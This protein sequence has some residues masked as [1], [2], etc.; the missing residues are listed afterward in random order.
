MVRIKNGNSPCSEQPL[1]SRSG[2]ANLLR[3]WTEMSSDPEH[4]DLRGKLSLI[5]YAMTQEASTEAPFTGAYWDHHGDWDVSLHRLRGGALRLGDEVRAGDRLAELLRRRRAAARHEQGES[6][7]R[8]AAHRGHLQPLRCSPRPLV[9]GWPAPDRH[10]VPALT[11]RRSSSRRETVLM[12]D[13][14]RGPP[15]AG[16]PDVQR[17]KGE[18]PASQR[19]RLR[20]LARVHLDFFPW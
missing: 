9:S 8:D 13:Q 18:R 10:A 1:H 5:Q 11:R 2:N 12:L 20:T 3:R 7:P 6:L 4:E 15:R 17:R 16:D 19:R 14:G